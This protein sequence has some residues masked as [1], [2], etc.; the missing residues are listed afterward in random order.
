MWT[1]RWLFDKRPE[2]RSPLYGVC[3]ISAQENRERRSDT[4]DVQ[5][6]VFE[7]REYA[8]AIKSGLDLPS[9]LL[10]ATVVD[11]YELR[12][13]PIQSEDRN[14]W[15]IGELECAHGPTQISFSLHLPVWGRR[16]CESPVRLVHPVVSWIEMSLELVQIAGTFRQQDRP[17][18]ST[19]VLILAT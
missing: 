9:R 18:E 11:P 3:D 10:A 6:F 4:R 12:R 2:T 19:L 16:L 7:N 13:Q 5:C 15:N 14:E 1:E 17:I 8:G